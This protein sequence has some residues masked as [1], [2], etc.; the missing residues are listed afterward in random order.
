M[1][2]RHLALVEDDEFS[3]QR[4]EQEHAALD[5]VLRFAIT[6]V[7]PEEQ[8][9]VLDFLVDKNG[10]EKDSDEYAKLQSFWKEIGTV[11]ADA[12]AEEGLEESLKLR[13]E[14]T[15]LRLFSR[16]MERLGEGDRKELVSRLESR[17]PEPVRNAE[18][19]ELNRLRVEDEA[20]A[21]QSQIDQRTMRA[22]R[23]ASLR[24]SAAK[25]GQPGID[26]KK[27]F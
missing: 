23:H 12:P 18:R 10:L 16:C 21:A 17:L 5:P 6:Q 13:R 26:D 19:N 22:F 3:D 14:D 4:P 25:N 11:Q 15:V 8:G 20:Q 7:P 2:H 1:E 24:N 9:P 27:N